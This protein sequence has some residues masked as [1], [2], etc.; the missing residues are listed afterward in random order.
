[1]TC[2]LVALLI[3]GL[4]FAPGCGDDDAGGGSDGDTDADTD[5]DTDADSDSDTDSDPPPDCPGVLD[6]IEPWGQ[7]ETVGDGS[8]GS[9][10]AQALADAVETLRPVEGGGT[11]L[12]DCGG[13]H[14][15]TLSASLF[16]DFPLMVDGEGAITI[17]G[18]GAVRI[19]ELD[20]HTEFT[21][22]R[23]NLVD[24]LTEE[25]GAAILHPWY[26]TLTAIDVVFENNH[27]TSQVDEIGGGAVF[28][29]G[30]SQAT[31]SGCE[32]HG[33]SASN[34]GGLFNR[35]SDLT[36]VACVFTQN[37]ATSSG[38]SGQFGNGG[39]IYIDG[40]NYDVPGDLLL[41][42]TV[43]EDN[44]A[45]QH[46]SAMF[47]YFYEGSQ[48]VI[49]RCLFSGNNFDGSPTGGAGGL[50][51]QVGHLTLTNSTLADNRSDQHAAALFVGS[52]STATVTNCTFAG[53]QV[54]EVGA[55]IFNGAS[56]V[57]VESSTFFG[58]DADYA[59]VLFKGEAAQY[60]LKNSLFAYNTTP[61][62]FSALAC[63]ESLGDLGGN[64]QWPDVKNND[65]PDTPCVADIEFAD[66]LLEPL[67]DNGGF[68][69]TMALGASS[70]AIDFGAECPPPETDQRGEPRV[71][72][73]DSGSFEV[74]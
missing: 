33:N 64:M 1:M 25:S 41:C 47:S 28:A 35:G 36:V 70:P 56:S 2:A 39:G 31:F 48:S 46:G 20:H 21:V 5:S 37:E 67:G 27:C 23:L 4:F 55:A 66:P 3:A 51:H 30:L 50:Y 24:G 6:P 52:G 43:F 34:G 13:E 44:R 65:N 16:V 61:N 26:G 73:C 60:S 11:I 68:T 72:P 40:M 58:N 10:T 17:S 29:G 18:G 54:P 22:Q 38:D 71:S 14:T 57:T 53:N 62:E 12:F 42:G 69:P 8:A 9:C 45:T 15:I 74:Q 19:F 63:H 7:V 59:P 32:F 49:D